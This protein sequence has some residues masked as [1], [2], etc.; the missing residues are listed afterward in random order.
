M[1]FNRNSEPLNVSLKQR[2]VYLPEGRKWYD[3]WSEKVYDGGQTINA[4]APLETLPLFIPSG[5]IIPM[6]PVMQYVDEKPD[7]PYEIRVYRGASCSFALYE[8][9]GDGYDHEKGG[10]AIVNLSWDDQ[11]NEFGISRRSG[12]FPGL[13]QS[14]EYELVFISDG[15]RETRKVSYCGDEIKLS[16]PKSEA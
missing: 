15:H 5:S 9:A 14:R 11:Q 8:D 7:A 2:A 10:Y 13:I 6:S 1:Y 16:V 4:D 12:S 3:F